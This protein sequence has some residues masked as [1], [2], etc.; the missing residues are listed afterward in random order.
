MTSNALR[1]VQ[2]LRGYKQKP[3]FVANAAAGANWAQRDATIF[4]SSDQGLIQIAGFVSTA[5]GPVSPAESIGVGGF[6]I[7]SK[8]AAKGWALYADIQ[9][10]N[11][12][13]SSYG[14]EVAAKN[15]GSNLTDTAYV[16][17]GGVYGVWLDAGGDT[18]YGG[19]SANPSN[20]AIKILANSNTWNTG[21]IFDAVG[22]TGT[23]GTTGTGTAIAMAKGHAVTWRAPSNNAG[24]TIR[25]D[26]ATAANDMSL[27]AADSSLSVLGTGGV[28]V[29]A[30]SHTASAVNYLF[31]KNATTGNW[32]TLQSQG[33]DANSYVLI[34][35]KGTS[36]VQL[37]DGGGT[38]RVQVNT[39]GVGFNGSAP[40]APSAG[41]GTP[42]GGGAIANFPGSACTLA[43]VGQAVSQL[44]LHL[45]SR[46]DIGA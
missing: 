11:G 4:A 34:K 45:K 42:T 21:I 6:L 5:N 39:N 30:F 37:V 24:F 14:L 10:E 19:S 35:G 1:N 36:G 33:T 46:G 38:V 18:S 20:A 44:L 15:K 3:G 31:L 13:G 26:V 28:S 2:A 22:I 17:A 25:S 40:I 29:A 41:W 43:Q 12:A 23:D 7:N 32:P 8:A 16:S 27:I 9:H